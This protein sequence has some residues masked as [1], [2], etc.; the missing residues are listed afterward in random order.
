M[1]TDEVSH[2]HVSGAGCAVNEGYIFK[3][4]TPKLRGF[5]AQAGA[6]T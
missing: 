3:G 1:K 6:K 2:A 4:H 5:S